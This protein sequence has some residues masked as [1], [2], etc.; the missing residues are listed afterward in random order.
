VP[1]TSRAIALS[2]RYRRDFILE[3]VTEHLDHDLAI[4]DAAGE[5]RSRRREPPIPLTV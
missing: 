3:S 2:D 4:V 1:V 5:Q